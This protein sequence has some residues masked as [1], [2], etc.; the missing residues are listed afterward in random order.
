MLAVSAK[1]IT[2][3]ARNS[4]Y[5]LDLTGTKVHF[6]TA[7][8]AVHLVDIDGKNYKDSTV[9]DLFD[10][11]KIVDRMDNI[12]FLQR[13]MVCRDILD[14]FE[15]D[16]NTIYACCRGTS[17]HIGTSF[18]DPKYVNGAI[19]LLHIIAG[20]EKNGGPVHLYQILIALWS[21]Q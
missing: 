21:H 6:G 10:A 13:P 5:D 1:N 17:K 12:H 15:M 9:Q 18:T 3:S 11:A 19:D 2:L 20:N 8:A 7:G 4:K 14:N 16:I